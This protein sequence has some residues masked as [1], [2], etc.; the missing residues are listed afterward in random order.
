MKNYPIL[1]AP[2][3]TIAYG[4]IHQPKKERAG[5]EYLRTIL[6]LHKHVRRE[7]AEMKNAFARGVR[8]AIAREVQMVSGLL[9]E[10]LTTPIHSDRADIQRIIAEGMERA[11]EQVGTTAEIGLL[12]SSEGKIGHHPFKK[13]AE[14]KLQQNGRAYLQELGFATEGGPGDI[15]ESQFILEGGMNLDLIEHIVRDRIGIY[16]APHGTHLEGSAHY[17]FSAYNLV[18]ASGTSSPQEHNKGLIEFSISFAKPAVEYAVFR[19][20]IIAG[21]ERHLP[22]NTVLH[23][24]LWQ[25]KLGMGRG[26]EF[27]L[28]FLCDETGKLDGIMQWL[29]ECREPDFPSD[30]LMEHGAMLAKELLV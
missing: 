21:L 3:P 11:S 5:E 1:N 25:R 20:S 27:I 13:A 10:Y 30:A 19:A 26:R 24:S 12:W 2:V 4:I 18:Y 22:V 28:R 8:E 7:S 23:T 6:D 9:S 29:Q 14:R 15:F 17:S 16:N